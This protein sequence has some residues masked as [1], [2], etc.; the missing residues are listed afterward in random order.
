[1]TT[2]NRMLAPTTVTRFWLKVDRSGECWLWTGSTNGRGYGHVRVNMCLT[3]AHRLSYEMSV[4]PIPEGLQIDHLCGN[5]LC[6]NPEHL[7]VVTAV[8][9]QLRAVLRAH[10]FESLGDYLD[11]QALRH[12]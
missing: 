5:T 2:A 8:E 7:E 6:V 10:G 9:N 3:Y 1:M 12:P 11:S 4:G